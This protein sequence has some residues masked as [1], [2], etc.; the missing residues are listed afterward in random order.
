MWDIFWQRVFRT[1]G[2][3][4]N[5]AGLAGFGEGIVAGVEVFALFEVFGEVIGFGRE[6]AV[7][8][9]EAL[10]VWGEGL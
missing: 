2:P 3:G 8:A 6:L 1:N 9:E 10:F 4:V 5:L 7:E